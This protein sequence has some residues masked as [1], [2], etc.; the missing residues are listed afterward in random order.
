MQ[1]P[2]RFV[3]IFAFVSLGRA[4]PSAEA[5]YEGIL[6]GRDTYDKKGSGMC[7]VLQ[8]K[9]C[10]EAVNNF[11]IRDD[12]QRYRPGEDETCSGGCSG[13]GS[14]T[15]SGIGCGVFVKGDTDCTRSGNQ[16]WHDYQ[17]IRNSGADKCGNKHWGDGCWT[18][19]DYVSACGQ[20][21]EVCPKL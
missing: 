10:D 18:T 13:L 19:I 6:E 3:T 1:F 11:I 21:K 14:K 17:D 7:N 20:I 4:L 2:A 8:V 9:F 12:V 5:D 15:Y 16:L